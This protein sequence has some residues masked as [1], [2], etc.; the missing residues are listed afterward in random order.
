MKTS[1]YRVADV[2]NAVIV[3]LQHKRIRTRVSVRIVKHSGSVR[4]FHPAVPGLNL[5]PGLKSKLKQN[6]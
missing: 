3:K 4:A 1:F 5:K 6:Q 2:A